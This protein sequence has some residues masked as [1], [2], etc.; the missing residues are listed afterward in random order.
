MR[1][2]WFKRR[3]SQKTPPIVHWK[4]RNVETH[5]SGEIHRPDLFLLIVFGVLV[6]LGLIT[7][8]SVSGVKSFE[9][10]GNN[11]Y[12][13]I[14]QLRNGALLGLILG[15]IAYKIPFQRLRFITWPLLGIS[16]IL[17]SLVFVPGVG[18]SSGGAARWIS[19]GPIFLQPS[20]IAKVALVLFLAMWLDRYK[21]KIHTWLYGVVLPLIPYVIIA[22][23][24]MFEPDLGTTLVLTAITLGMLF[25]GGVPWKHILAIIG[26]GL[27]SV[28]VLTILEPYR[29]ARITVFFDP[30][31]DP[32]GIGYQINQVFIA[33]GTG[34]WFGL[35]LGKSLQKYSYLP[36]AT[37]DSIFA[38][39]AE[40]F[41]FLRM[42]GVIGLYVIIA[43]RG[44]GIAQKVQD[45]FP[46]LI[47][48]GIVLW[49]VFQALINIGANLALI[50]FTGVPLPFISYGS[51]ALAVAMAAA[52]L[53]LQISRHTIERPQRSQQQGT[54]RL[55]AQ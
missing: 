9:L 54:S 55:T 16:V 53:L 52:G 26:V 21:A 46:K 31:H 50:P 34:G 20:E 11:T 47:V 35:G 51:S 36:E 33:I 30:S 45:L 15:I 17:L 3:P 24:V 14:H 1:I 4:K 18:F 12:Y 13:F 2:P 40:E 27:L 32:L 38:I 10:F 23:L 25:V 29:L 37:G 5:A 49:F 41:G 28:V 7:V 44:L 6:V 22:G 8:L 42:I 43:I 39:M 48:T 19:Y